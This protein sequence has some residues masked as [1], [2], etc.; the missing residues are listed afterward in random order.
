MVNL[1]AS[2]VNS[3]EMSDT[4]ATTANVQKDETR[5]SIENTN[6]VVKVPVADFDGLV[7]IYFVVAD[8]DFHSKK[9]VVITLALGLHLP[10]SDK[11]VTTLA[12]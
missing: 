6:F 11:A 8:L 9:T 12:A 10:I 5:S 7:F 1:A 4:T 3:N 2:K